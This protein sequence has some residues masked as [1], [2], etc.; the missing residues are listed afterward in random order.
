MRFLSPTNQKCMELS[1]YWQFF[2]Y[3]PP[4]KFQWFTHLGK[5]VKLLNCHTQT[6]T[7]THIY[8]AL[9]IF[10]MDF[11]YQ[12]DCTTFHSFLSWNIW[13]EN[14]FL[15]F[16]KVGRSVI[17]WLVG[18]VDNHVTIYGSRVAEDISAFQRRSCWLCSHHRILMKF[19]GVIT[20]DESKVHAK[21]QGQMS[22]SQRSQPNLTV[23]GL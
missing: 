19:S 11:L 4:G 10:D 7:H 14:C 6:H 20:N 23:S 21:G 12:I 1:T 22:R 9:L 16:S 2:Y 8:M 15:K 13:K 5:I 3:R 18:E 17:V